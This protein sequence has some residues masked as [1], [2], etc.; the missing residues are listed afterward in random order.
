VG[1]SVIPTLTLLTFPLSLL[2]HPARASF[3]LP[4]FLPYPQNHAMVNSLPSIAAEKLP[5]K[6]ASPSQT[7]YL[8][9]SGLPVL[10]SVD[11]EK[12]LLLPSISGYGICM[13][14]AGI[15]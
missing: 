14:K 12:R 9:L 13:K 1:K 5:P 2:L 6:Q 7:M 3:L 8:K 11:Q 4:S 15:N 10:V